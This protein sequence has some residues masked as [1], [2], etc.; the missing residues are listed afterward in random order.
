MK[1][2]L[3]NQTDY[4]CTLTSN[5]DFIENKTKHGLEL[6]YSN[7][8]QVNDMRIDLKSENWKILWPNREG[9]IFSSS[10]VIKAINKYQVS[11][12]LS[13]SYPATA[14][15]RTLIFMEENGRGFAFLAPPD[16]EGRVTE[17]CINAEDYKNVSL[18]IKCKNTNWYTLSFITFKELEDKIQDLQSSVPWKGLGIVETNSNWQIQVGLIGPDGKTEVPKN[19]GFDVLVDISDLMLKKLGENNILHIFGYSI[20]HDMGYPDYTPSNQ[21][22]GASHLE[23]AIERIHFNK[24]KAV[25]YMNGR[26]ADRENIEK[27]GLHSSILTDKNNLPIMETYH[28]RDF[29]VM[30]PSSEEWQDRLL[31]EAIKLKKLGADGVQL[32]QLGGRAS[33]VPAGET[34][35]KGYINLINNL[36]KERLT[37]WIQG[38][39]DIYP[40]DWFELTY[41]DIN[42]LEDGTIRGG[43]PLGKP[44]KR[45]FQISVP[46]QIL[47]IPLS[48]TETKIKTK[49]KNNKTIID[50]NLGDEKL[51]LYNP[52]YMTQLEKLIHKAVIK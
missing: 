14:S 38:L 20:G 2:I 13:L 43:T 44:D 9:E 12:G 21:L 35:G 40:A 10:K 52:L 24:Q 48:K 23:K 17:L 22:G 3:Y 37:V 41:R 31:A 5:L 25:F 34:W 15:C 32:D 50:L 30:N 39:S 26:I 6:A 47:L 45:V 7:N 27:G 8:N 4:Y 1:K 33:P 42:I 11:S 19:K 29:Y 28:T 18:N 36:H 16:R 49:S 51:F 46:G